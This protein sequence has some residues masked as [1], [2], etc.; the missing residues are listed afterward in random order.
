[1]KKIRN[2]ICIKVL[3]LFLYTGFYIGNTAFVHT[4]YYRFYSVTHSHPYG[5]NAE[6]KPAHTHDK[7]SLETI[8]Q[9]NSFSVDLIP[10][11]ILE[12][13]GVLLLIFLQR[14]YSSV[15]LLRVV[16]SYNLRAPP[17]RL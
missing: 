12:A 3:L 11:F 10:F 7:A 13:A 14:R 4:H 16:D 17:F 15:V 1:M 5:K 9:F 2:N 8:A 6:G